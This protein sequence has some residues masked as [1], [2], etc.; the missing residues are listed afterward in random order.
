MIGVTN[1]AQ[2]VA[3]GDCK[4][5]HIQQ[6]SFKESLKCHL[7]TISPIGINLSLIQS[8]HTISLIVICDEVSVE[9]NLE[10]GSLSHLRFLKIIRYRQL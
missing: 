3:P 4:W 2:Y 8:E 10:N 7:R 9:S 1:D 5:N 6:H